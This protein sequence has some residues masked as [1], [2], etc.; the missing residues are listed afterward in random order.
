MPWLDIMYKSDLYIVDTTGFIYSIYLQLN[1]H[2]PLLPT[3]TKVALN[4][5]SV[6]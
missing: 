3:D 1:I 4:K 6:G 2:N 5:Y